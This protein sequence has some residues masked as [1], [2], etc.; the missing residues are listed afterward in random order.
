MHQI[1][2]S[3]WLTWNDSES[4]D[5][6]H[7]LHDCFWTVHQTDPMCS[8]TRVFE[9]AGIYMTWITVMLIAIMW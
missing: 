6:S 2:L 7:K 4:E 8:V 5:Y 3:A 9:T 1:K